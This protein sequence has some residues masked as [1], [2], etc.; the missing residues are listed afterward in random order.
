MNAPAPGDGWTFAKGLAMAVA[1]LGLVGFGVC[2]LCGAAL[3]FED[4]T[5]AGN[6]G[7]WQLALPCALLGGAIAAGLFFVVRSIVRSARRGGPPPAP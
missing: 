6:A 4:L 1:L 5:N 2:A 7:I 3:T